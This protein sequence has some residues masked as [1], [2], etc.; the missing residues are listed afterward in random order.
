MDPQHEAQIHALWHDPTSYNPD[1]HGPPYLSDSVRTASVQ[2]GEAAELWQKIV[3]IYADQHP[4]TNG[5]ELAILLAFLKAEAGLHQ[6]HHWRTQG[7]NFYS[8]HLLFERIYN[9]TY[10]LIDGLAERTIGVGDPSLLQPLELELSTFAIMRALYEETD[11]S[12]GDFASL[13]LRAVHRFL[14][15]ECLAYESLQAKG[16]LSHGL[17][18][19][20]QGLADK[21]EEFIYLLSQKT[22]GTIRA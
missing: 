19:L 14:A 15:V 10:G 6:S 5:V 17:D 16:Q 21:H 11:T 22:S 13:S 9:E 12:T 18:N 3:S 7:P 1:E 20:L 8:D 2:G 4:N